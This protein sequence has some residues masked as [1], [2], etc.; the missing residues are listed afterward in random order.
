[1]ATAF[2]TD[3]DLDVFSAAAEHEVKLTDQLS[4][5]L[6]AGWA[7]QRRED[8][9]DSDYTYL[10][11]L[12][13]A[14]RDDT[15]LRGNV[16]RKIR[17]PTLRNLYGL[18]EGNEDLQ[19]EVTR[20]YEVGLDQR[21]PAI[22]GLFSVSVFRI[23][24]ENFIKKGTCKDAA[25]TF[26]CN[27]NSLRFQGVETNLAFSPIDRLNLQIGYT[28]LN[29]KN[30]APGL[31]DSDPGAGVTLVPASDKLDNNPRHKFMAAASYAI[32]NGTT[33]LADYQF[34]AASFS[35][36]RNL[37]DTLRL[38]DYHLLNLGFT[39]DI[40]GGAF[41]FYGRVE[42]VLDEN[43]KSSFGFP[44]SGR[45]FFAGVRTKLSVEHGTAGRNGLSRGSISQTNEDGAIPSGP[46]RFRNSIFDR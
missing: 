25:S 34:V 29:S 16:A 36:S 12:R 18:G 30:L 14:L 6:G 17:F 43:Y 24:A 20:N 31:A 19:T 2:N 4:A 1:M 9:R 42:N 46:R 3:N 8:T 5:V 44:E 23:D 7:E 27:F 15:V 28:F 41:Q 37:I 32:G 26:F 33:L 45:I 40:E 11:G 21:L 35:V 39:Q 10:A 38:H 13:Y 22:N